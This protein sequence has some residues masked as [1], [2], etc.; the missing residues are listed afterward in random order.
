MLSSM[1]MNIVGSEW[2]I[3]ILLGVVLVF[4][5]KRLPQFSRNLGR[6]MGEYEK[7]R[8][9]FRREITDAA[10]TANVMN[11]IPLI[12]GPVSTEREKLETIASSLGIEGY[13][14]LSDE[15]LRSLIAKRMAS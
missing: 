2:I 8:E 12:K 14:N 13:L 9:I 11:K 1:I 5:P 4:G 10:G 15:D 3:L 6:A 7:A